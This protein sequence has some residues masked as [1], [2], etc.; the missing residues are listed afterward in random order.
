MHVHVQLGTT[1]LS[2][3]EGGNKWGMLGEQR[4]QQLQP[5]YHWRKQH[6]RPNLKSITSNLQTNKWTHTANT[7]A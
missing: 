4:E 1:Y 6:R 2:S 3:S 5:V 7:S